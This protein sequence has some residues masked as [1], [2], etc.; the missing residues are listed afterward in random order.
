MLDWN[1]MAKV[2]QDKETFVSHFGPN[3]TPPHL[4]YQVNS[5][6]SFNQRTM[7]ASAIRSAGTD[8][9]KDMEAMHKKIDQMQRDM[10]IGF[11]H[12]KINLNAVWNEVRVLANMVSTMSAL[13]HNNPLAIIDQREE[14]MKKDI[15]GQLELSIIQTN[16]TIMRMSDLE[17]KQHLSDK[18]MTLKAKYNLVTNECANILLV[19]NHLIHNPPKTTF[20]SPT[21]F[22]PPGLLHRVL[23][24]PPPPTL[25]MSNP[26]LPASPNTSTK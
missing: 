21:P 5:D 15:L 16:M 22:V 10:N 20:V 3:L 24:P 6:S 11:Q 8:V 18:M 25:M 4:L 14:R 9:V 7:T 2:L 17:E 19:I 23:P 12:A 26:Q 13:V 1:A